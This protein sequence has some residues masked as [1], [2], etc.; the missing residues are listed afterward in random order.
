MSF[1]SSPAVSSSSS[2]S[3]GAGS[4]SLR[5]PSADAKSSIHTQQEG[6]ALLLQS[7]MSLHEAAS[8]EKSYADA[9]E[10]YS[11]LQHASND[12]LNFY[13]LLVN[14]FSVQEIA[15]AQAQQRPSDKIKPHEIMMLDPED[16]KYHSL[17]VEMIRDIREKASSVQEGSPQAAIALL[18]GIKDIS[19]K[20][21]PITYVSICIQLAFLSCRLELWPQVDAAL[22]EIPVEFLSD[23]VIGAEVKRLRDFLPAGMSQE[24]GLA[25]LFTM[26]TEQI[27]QERF[28]DAARSLILAIENLPAEYKSHPYISSEIARLDGIVQEGRGRMGARH[29]VSAPSS[30]MSHALALLVEPRKEKLL[31]PLNAED[32]SCLQ[33]TM[34]ILSDALQA[35]IQTTLKLPSKENKGEAKLAAAVPPSMTQLKRTCD[36]LR[37]QG[38]PLL[39]SSVS[40]SIF[41]WFRND[42]I[43]KSTEASEE[44]QHKNFAAAIVRYEAASN[45]YGMALVFAVIEA[46]KTAIAKAQL[47]A[48]RAMGKCREA[49]AASIAAAASAVSS[50]PAEGARRAATPSGS[51]APMPR[52]AGAPAPAPK[53]AEAKEVK[54]DIAAHS[55]EDAICLNATMTFLSAALKTEIRTTLNLSTP[56]AKGELLA[57]ESP[58]LSHINRVCEILRQRG[59]D[60]LVSRVRTEVCRQAHQ[61]GLSESIR[62]AGHFG[63]SE[64]R[65]ASLLYEAAIKKIGIAAALATAADT[66]IIVKAQ[67]R[68]LLEFRQCKQAIAEA[69]V[70]SATGAGASL[71]DEPAVIVVAP[72]RLSKPPE[73]SWF[74]RLF[75]DKPSI[76]AGGGSDKFARVDSFVLPPDASYDSKAAAVKLG[77]VSAAA[78]PSASPAKKP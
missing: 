29:P 15:K 28:G 40:N 43:Q 1:N 32:I 61:T 57:T 50:G 59:A 68:V 64:L 12:S 4:L 14:I 69:A 73:T 27:A 2:S 51:S 37:Q 20:I 10:A 45:S 5:V 76:G 72:K 39:V 78:V 53:K 17:F 23:P 30:S 42:G 18:K 11:L 46:D 48:T 36:I 71:A 9:V 34:T 77:S 22:S 24:R 47:V 49:Q 55:A 35:E 70:G 25:D 31:P 74:A 75:G 58:S 56:D 13:D 3:S 63:K 26:V 62:A 44:R 7:A 41:N 16:A 38:Q 66:A 54:M 33:A 19:K 52:V 6:L 8:D 65:E 67:Q 21:N 60:S